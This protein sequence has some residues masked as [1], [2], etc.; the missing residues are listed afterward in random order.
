MKRD[1]GPPQVAAS[2]R[3]H[4]V[5]VVPVVPCT[6]CGQD[7]P[8]DHECPTA[9]AKV[10]QLLAVAANTVHPTPGALQAIRART[11]P[12]A[13]ATAQAAAPS[14]EDDAMTTPIP[15]SQHTV[16][17]LQEMAGNVRTKAREVQAEATELYRA[18]DEIDAIITRLLAERSALLAA[19]EEEDGG[20]E[21]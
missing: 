13:P 11:C 9:T 5:V 21:R 19:G 12:S 8:V 3:G 6:P 17:A 4:R 1:A 7:M 20:G 14:E 18:A 15:H 16:P 2:L 10:R